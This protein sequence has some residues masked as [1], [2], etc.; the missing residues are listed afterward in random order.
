M[1]FGTA[2]SYAFQDE[3]WLK[4]IAIGAVLVLTGIG[5]IPVLGWM[6]EIVR[7][8]KDGD[9]SLPDWADFG[10]LF[11][12]GLKAMAVGLIWAIPGIV[13]GGCIGGG[14]AMIGQDSGDAMVFGGYA[15]TILSSC[16]A[17]P[18]YLALLLLMPPMIGVLSDT[19]N[20]GEALNPA[21]SF[22]LFRNNIGGYLIALVVQMFGFPILTSIGAIACGVG[23]FPAAAYGYTIIGN[24]YGQAYAAAQSA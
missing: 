12:D 8:S 7:R 11:V 15:L 23:M 9:Y 19:G 18:Y 17:L 2:F 20:F 21:N 24:L 13:I 14:V 10:T 3:E 4:K 1:D 6:M 5:M 22:K 16:V